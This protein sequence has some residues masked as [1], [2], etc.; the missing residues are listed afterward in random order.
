MAK[1]MLSRGCYV[2]VVT[3]PPP[4]TRRPRSVYGVGDD[5]DPRFSLANERT[6]LAWLRT[7]LAFVAAGTGLLVVIRS[8]GQLRGARWIGVL[9]CI[10]GALIAVGAVARWR[11][12]ERALRLSQ[13]LPAPTLLLAAVV[14]IAVLAGA[15][16]IIDLV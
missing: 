4:D 9:G 7:A 11:S 1:V 2:P 12:I 6:A 15:L 8:Q 3:T 16:V 14:T 10:V 5:P 13:P